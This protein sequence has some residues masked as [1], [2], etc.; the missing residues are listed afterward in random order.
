MCKRQ[1]LSETAFRTIR[2]SQLGN[3][4][5][6]GNHVSGAS[7]LQG[8]LI[9]VAG[10]MFSNA[11]RK[12]QATIARELRKGSYR[13]YL[14]QE[15]G[16]EMLQLIR[17]METPQLQSEL[18]Y[19]ASLMVQNI[20]WALEIYQ[21][22]Q[23]DGLVLNLNGRVPDEGSV[24]EATMAF[25]IGK[26]VVTFKDSSVTMWGLFDNPMV[27][28][29]DRTWQPVRKLNE[30]SKAMNAAFVAAGPAPDAT[31]YT[32][33]PPQH[34]ADVIALGEYVHQHR[35]QLR[36]ALRQATQDIKTSLAALAPLLAAPANLSAVRAFLDAVL[37]DQAPQS[38]PSVST[39]G[40]RSPWPPPS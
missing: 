33:Q 1:R 19:K 29:L 26:P 9:F 38:A 25:V 36:K 7:P 15:D 24:M 35:G 10:P 22:E 14:A 20:G 28:A 3:D 16:F 4:P 37:A 12:E 6:E 31:P 40:W 27:A 2:Q 8:K 32:Y 13:T 39:P 17:A 21:L 34:L 18:L 23:C 5:V 11:E 30:L